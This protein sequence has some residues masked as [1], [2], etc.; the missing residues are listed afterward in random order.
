[1]YLLGTTQRGSKFIELQLS[2]MNEDKSF[3][4][5][6]F[7]YWSKEKD[8]VK[9]R[10]TNLSWTMSYL[11]SGELYRVAMLHGGG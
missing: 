4:R 8:V 9:R 6:K 3:V 10:P 1:V 2:P 5:N 7:E 11:D